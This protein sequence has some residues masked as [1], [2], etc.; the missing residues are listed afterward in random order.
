M[1][2]HIAILVEDPGAANYVAGLGAEL[3]ARGHAVH[4][5]A[6]DPA[7]R[8]LAR[9]GEAFE[10]APT[11]PKGVL[12]PGPALVVVGTGE[13]PDALAL[14][15]VDEARRE[16]IVTVGIVDAPINEDFRFRGRG[17]SPLTHAPDAVLTVD[18]RAA[19]AF[20][21]MGLPRCRVF[22]CGHPMFDRV[23]RDAS[24]LA[25]EDRATVRGRALPGLP[26]ERPVLLVL[27]ERLGGLNGPQ[28]MRSADYTLAGRGGSDHRQHIVLEEVLNA[29]A[30]LKR[31]PILVLRLHPKADPE[32]FAPYLPAFDAVSTEGPATDLLMA[33]DAVIG[34]TTTLLVEA[35]LLGRPTLSVVPRERERDWLVT[36][37]ARVTRCA[38]RRDEIRPAIE[39]TLA[40]GPPDAARLDRLFPTGATRRV[41]AVLEDLLVNGL[42]ETGRGKEGRHADRHSQHG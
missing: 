20:V 33:A 39:A 29:V 37:G 1:S 26:Q 10:P 36:I 4:L 21:R 41:G 24:R 38:S 28:F 30:G 23:R 25:A 18:E 34:T 22:A 16:N 11:D 5:F 7:G 32:D 9:L 6:A 27:A 40:E 42:P 35:A 2:D 8:L 12:G 14:E 13:D 31:T 3:A 15:L 17:S 19:D